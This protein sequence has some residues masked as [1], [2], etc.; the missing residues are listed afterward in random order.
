MRRN[1]DIRGNHKAQIITSAKPA[2]KPSAV[3]SPLGA[4]SRSSPPSIKNEF[5]D[6]RM[7]PSTSPTKKR[8]IFSGVSTK[9]NGEIAPIKVRKIKRSVL[10]KPAVKFGV[11]VKLINISAKRG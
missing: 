1:S 10:S 3:V 4:V 8:R 9:R 2:E 5:T 11:Y 7:P 6:I